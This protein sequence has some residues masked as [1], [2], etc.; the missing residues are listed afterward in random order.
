MQLGFD[1]QPSII[2]VHILQIQKLG[3]KIAPSEETRLDESKV[4][5]IQYANVG[6]SHKGTL[7]ELRSSYCSTV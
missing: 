7:G 3:K 6:E 1:F 2:Q 4:K 5:L